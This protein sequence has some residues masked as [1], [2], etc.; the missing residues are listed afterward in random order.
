[1]IDQRNILLAIV[2]SIGILVAWQF[3]FVVPQAERQA[4]VLEQQTTSQPAGGELSTAQVGSISNTPKLGASVPSA[5]QETQQTYQIML[6]VIF[7]VLKQSN[8]YQDM[9]HF[10]LMEV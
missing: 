1:M 2:L 3:I 10:I 5:L 8:L 7:L 9:I 6:K 4:Q